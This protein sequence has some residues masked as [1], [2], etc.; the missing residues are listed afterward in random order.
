[1]RTSIHRSNWLKPLLWLFGG[2]EDRSYVEIEGDTLH[3]RFGFLFDE[4]VPLDKITSV[5]REKWPIIAGLGWRTNLI[6]SIA[7]VGSYSNVVGL[8]LSPRVPMWL[9]RRMN[10][11][12]LYVSVDDP[13]AFV[14]EIRRRIAERGT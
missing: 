3:V 14:D 4:R 10:V 6:D 12:S 5:E 13:D 7:V 1:M 9:V 2:T 11:E 8:R